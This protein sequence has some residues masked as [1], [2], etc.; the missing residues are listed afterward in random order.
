MLAE[1]GVSAVGSRDPGADEQ[2]DVLG[3]LERAGAVGAKQ[4]DGEDVAAEPCHHVGGSQPVAQHLGQV[5]EQGVTCGVPECRDL[6]ER[7]EADQSS[8]PSG[9]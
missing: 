7:V 5:D 1:N 3:D 9:P 6:L 8:A 4:Q 2:P